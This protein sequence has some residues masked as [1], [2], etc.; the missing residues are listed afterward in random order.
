MGQAKARRA[1]AETGRAWPRDQVPATKVPTGSPRDWLRNEGRK[2][3]E[4]VPCGTC[5]ACCSAGYAIAMDDGTTLKPRADGT[6]PKLIDGACSIYE[7]RPLTC[8]RYD[9]RRYVFAGVSPDD[10]VG[11]HLSRWDLTADKFED[12]VFLLS[13]RLALQH[14]VTSLA[15]KCEND[16]SKFAFQNAG[17]YK[18]E[19]AALLREHGKGRTFNETMNFIRRGFQ[20]ARAPTI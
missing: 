4:N 11:R 6:C 12:Q 3:N 7:D 16:L 8:R 5:T 13:C 18:E 15:G 10:H 19:A 17:R 9:C 1:A 2:P 14:N 20:G